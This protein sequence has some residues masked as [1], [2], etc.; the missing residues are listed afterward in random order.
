MR[1]ETDGSQ[2]VQLETFPC[3]QILQDKND[4]KS[5]EELSPALVRDKKTRISHS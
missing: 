5:K 1:Q 3:G 4:G 2:A